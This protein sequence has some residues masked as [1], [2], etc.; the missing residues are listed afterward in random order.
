MLLERE[1]VG[2]GAVIKEEVAEERMDSTTRTPTRCW[3]R[4]AK[5][6]VFEKLVLW[7]G[8]WVLKK[9]VQGYGL[10][11]YRSVKWRG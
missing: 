1:W 6:S 11:R 7:G 2:R 3:K 5:G 10:Q 9:S 4:V 8:V